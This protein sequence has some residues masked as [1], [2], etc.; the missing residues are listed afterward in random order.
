MNIRNQAVFSYRNQDLI[1]YRHY[2]HNNA[3]N[4]ILY[5]TNHEDEFFQATSFD[6][7]TFKGLEIRA[8][9][10]RKEIARLYKLFYESV[11]KNL[12]SFGNPILDF[13]ENLIEK[14]VA[15]PF[16]YDTK[17][18]NKIFEIILKDNKIIG[19]YYLKINPEDS[20]GYLNF[21]AL[22]DKFKRTKTGFA[23]LSKMANSIAK[24][25]QQND[26]N[27]LTWETNYTNL[28]ARKLFKKLNA[29]NIG[30]AN[31]TIPL[32]GF[33]ISTEDFKNNIEKLSKK[34]I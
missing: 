24:N 8:V 5:K 32:L 22:S 28:Q 1:N 2:I 19:G 16:L 18:K 9:E 30:Q 23:C 15:I 17:D 20:S 13:F 31:P 4:N 14:I 25:L 33:K 6:K 7:T 29:E 12:P 34:I 3:N 11:N 21:I 10:N 27:E 26:L